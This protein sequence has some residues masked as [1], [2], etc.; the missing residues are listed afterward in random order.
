MSSEDKNLKAGD[1]INVW[2]NERKIFHVF[3]PNKFEDI[4]CIC[5]DENGFDPKEE[6]QN[7]KDEER[8]VLNEMVELG[9][10]G[11]WTILY[12]PGE[13]KSFQELR[14]NVVDFDELDVPDCTTYRGYP[15]LNNENITLGFCP[16]ENKLVMENVKKLGFNNRAAIKNS[17]YCICY[18]CKQLLSMKKIDI[19]THKDLRWQDNN[20]TMLCPICFEPAVLAPA[21]FKKEEDLNLALVFDMNRYWY[22]WS[23]Y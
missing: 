10:K 3:P 19:N 8:A 7:R 5:I 21:S 11:N 20:Q 16:D 14:H 9:F 13:E 22:G 12:S 6:M 18:C 1:N 2:G 4:W 15:N 17:S 23:H